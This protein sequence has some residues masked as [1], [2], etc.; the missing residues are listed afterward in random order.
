MISFNYRHGELIVDE[1]AV[2]Y[3]TF[4]KSGRNRVKTPVKYILYY[5]G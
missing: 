1:F 3:I 2:L 4:G 5:N